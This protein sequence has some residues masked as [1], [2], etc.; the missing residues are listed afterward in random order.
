MK[1]ICHNYDADLLGQ[2]RGRGIHKYSIYTLDLW[3]YT[4]HLIS[5][6]NNCHVQGRVEARQVEAEHEFNIKP[7]YRQSQP[8]S[9]GQD[10]A[11][12]VLVCGSR[13]GG[14]SKPDKI[15]AQQCRRH[16]T[17]I[18]QICEPSWLRWK[19]RQNDEQENWLERWG[20]W[21]QGGSLAVRAAECHAHASSGCQ[22]AGERLRQEGTAEWIGSQAPAP[23]CS[24]VR[25]LCVPPMHIHVLCATRQPSSV[26]NVANADSSLNHIPDFTA[27]SLRLP[28]RDKLC[29]NYECAPPMA[30]RKWAKPA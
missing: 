21:G 18:I 23:F 16:L 12:C 20:H 29:G 7:S 26:C 2:S 28:R 24:T 11:K 27:P 9:R 17:G 6:F 25:A 1:S 3:L 15:K 30:V 13:D 5:T 10:V 19:R 4:L 8:V 14:A 22:R